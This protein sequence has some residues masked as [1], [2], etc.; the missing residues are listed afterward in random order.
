MANVTEAELKQIAEL[1]LDSNKIAVNNFNVTKD[2]IIGAVDKIGKMEMIDS[3]FYDKLTELDGDNLPLG[4]T[5]EEYYQDLIKPVDWDRDVDGTKAKRFWSPTYRPLSYSYSLG[6]KVIPE[7]IPNGDIDRAVNSIEQSATIIA[8]MTKRVSDSKATYKYALKRGM[9]GKLIEKVKDA[10]TNAT[11]YVSNT[12]DIVEGNTYVNTDNSIYAICV[13]SK[14]HLESDTFDLL[15]NSGYL[16][17]MQMQQTIAKP[18]DTATGEAFL[19]AVKEAVEHANDVSEGFSFNGNTIG[20]EYGLTLYVKQGVMP[21]VQVQTLAGAFNKD[22]LNT[23]VKIKVIK[24]FG[25]NSGSTYAV[26]VD[27]RGLKLHTDYDAM[28][29]D[30]NGFGDFVSL[31]D[32]TEYTA[33]I[34]RNTFVKIFNAQ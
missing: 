23:G 13:K 1:Y 21:T 8:K 9:I 15:I 2:N 18:V 30:S 17:P 6:R 12:T 34:S 22:E 10:Y 19:V 29:E 33:F 14:Q 3:T 16:V 5:I 32:H 31:F 20:A 11:R 27:E 7:S 28:R 4:K 24:D 26:L 25:A